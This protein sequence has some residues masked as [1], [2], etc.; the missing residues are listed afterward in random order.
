L[1]IKRV[2]VVTVG[3]SMLTAVI[4][5]PIVLITVMVAPPKAVVAWV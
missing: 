3:K 4:V 5:A 1:R 2:M